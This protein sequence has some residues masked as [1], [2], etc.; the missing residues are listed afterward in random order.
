M[1]GK[2]S[3]GGSAGDLTDLRLEAVEDKRDS[4]LFNALVD[5]Y[6]Y[7]G[8]RPLPG[9]RLRYPVRNGDTVVGAIGFGEAAWKVASRDHWIGWDADT[10]EERLSRILN[11]IRFPILPWIEVRNLASRI[12]SLSVK[13][14]KTDMPLQYGFNGF[15]ELPNGIPSHD[16]FC[17]VFYWVLDLA[18]RE[19]RNRK[20]YM[21]ENFSLLRNI[22]AN[23]LRNETS[24]KRGIKRKLEGGMGQR[25]P[26]KGACL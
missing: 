22:T 12:L 21:A 20:G 18:F 1:A 13:R 2:R 19:D 15:L 10:R 17:S 3:A 24:S 25:L 26:C 11:N 7:L 6:H 8:Y 9:A 23:M 14:L 5:R 4:R 16:T